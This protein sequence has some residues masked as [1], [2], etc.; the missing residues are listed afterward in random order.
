MVTAIHL[1]S[2]NC[3]FNE[4]AGKGYTVWVWCTSYLL[5]LW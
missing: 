4:A 5:P 2:T 3:I 1:I